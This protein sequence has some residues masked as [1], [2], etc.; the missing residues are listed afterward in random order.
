MTVS[1]MH[2]VD[3]SCVA[4]LGYDAASEEV[5]VEFHSSETYAY[6]GVSSQVYE[7]FDGAESKGRFF[8]EVIKPTY[9]VRKL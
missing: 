1:G 5:H 2:R 4:R 6:G 3:S 8:N 9:P 7:E